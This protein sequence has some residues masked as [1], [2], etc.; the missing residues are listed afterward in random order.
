MPEP[1]DG[2]PES[3]EARKVLGALDREHR[4]RRRLLLLFLVLLLIPILVGLV[5]LQR[6]REERQAQ[7][8]IEGR[9][10]EIGEDYQRVEPKLRQVAALDTVLPRLRSADQQLT[11]QSRQ[12]EELGG[13]QGNL[14]RDFEEAAGSLE[15]QV[16][17]VRGSVERLQSQVGGRLDDYVARLAEVEAFPSDLEALQR[18][19]RALQGDVERLRE[20]ARGAFERLNARTERVEG[21]FGDLE[22]GV[23]RLEAGL[24]RL[25]EQFEECG[26]GG[27]GVAGVDP[28]LR[29][30]L[31]RQQSQIRE[32]LG[33]I[34]EL[35]GQIA[36]LRGPG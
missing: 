18:G 17:D 24:S 27:E 15:T 9:V 22:G 34:A 7:L 26:C 32:L 6:G 5:A 16:T 35:E 25:R 12:I 33:R 8:L 23:A 3:E 31:E 20:G 10:D 28:E 4:R 29:Q 1:N 36:E 30:H 14:E 19:Q 13:R 21:A 2:L 11:A